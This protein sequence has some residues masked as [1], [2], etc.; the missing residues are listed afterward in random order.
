VKAIHII[1]GKCG[2]CM[3]KKDLLSII[4]LQ[5]NGNGKERVNEPSN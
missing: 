2:R 4:K 5:V 3:K 1:C